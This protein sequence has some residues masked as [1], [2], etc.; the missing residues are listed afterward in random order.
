M[1][2]LSNQ[3]LK[4]WLCWNELF[5][6]FLP[7]AFFLYSLKTSENLAVFWC[8]QGVEKRCTGNKWVISA[9]INKKL[10][11]DELPLKFPFEGHDIFFQRLS[12]ENHLFVDIDKVFENYRHY[13]NNQRGNGA[14]FKCGGLSLATIWCMNSF[15]LFGSSS[16][17]IDGFN[18]PNDA[19]VLL[20]FR[21]MI[22]LNNFIKSFFIN[23]SSNI[24]EKVCVTQCIKERKKQQ[25]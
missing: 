18:D 15:F 5:N 19:D 20:E 21:T 3:L 10:A 9:G 7:K 17:N 6:S 8:F 14:I 16:H 13:K 23:C 1:F 25:F 24:N 11:I 12:N 4:R 2:L 22:S